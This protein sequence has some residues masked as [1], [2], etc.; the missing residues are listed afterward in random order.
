M[1]SF[2]LETDI[3]ILN[4]GENVVEG[5]SEGIGFMYIE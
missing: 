5:L 2:K 4:L 1:A 3:I